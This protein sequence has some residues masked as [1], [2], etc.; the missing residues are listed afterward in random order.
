MPGPEGKLAFPT[1]WVQSILSPTPLGSG[2]SHRYC[3]ECGEEEIRDI[4]PLGHDYEEEFTIDYEAT[5]TE[6][7][8]KSRHCTRCDSRID[9][10]RF[11]PLGHDYSDEITAPTCTEKGYTTHTCTRCHD[12]F[13]D[14]YTEPTGHSFGEWINHDSTCTSD[15]Y[16][17]RVCEVCGYEESKTNIIN[18]PYD[19][20]MT[21]GK[22]LETISKKENVENI[23]K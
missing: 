10:T 14:N 12:S 2:Q 3:S 5:C 6:D 7:G 22:I 17:T 23:K 11:A 20:E 19:R 9:I 21:Y 15:G 18:N 13:V 16:Q 4:N 1:E 8:I